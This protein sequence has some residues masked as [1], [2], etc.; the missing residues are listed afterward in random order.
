MGA[1]PDTRREE[2]PRPEPPARDLLVLASEE[3]RGPLTSVAGYLNVLLDGEVGELT[4]GQARMAAIAARN[5]ERLERLVDDLIVVAQ[6][7][8]DG[9][10]PARGPVDMAALV[11]ERV[12]AASEDLRARGAVVSVACGPCPDVVGDLPAL[13]H[14]L[15]HMLAASIAF[16]EYGGAMEVRVQGWRDDTVQVEV[17]DDGLAVAPDDLAGLFDARPDGC[18]TGPRAMLASRL[19]LYLVR[20]VA[21]AHG[22]TAD[23]RLE[24]GCTVLRVVL[25]GDGTGVGGMRTPR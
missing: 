22:G 16:L 17:R 7:H 12:A 20:A 5:A 18:P 8:A 11:R 10:A 1:A 3:L 15:D 24:D 2:S 21:Q 23:A 9:L 4:E 19:G 6:V 13:A 14:M 25:P